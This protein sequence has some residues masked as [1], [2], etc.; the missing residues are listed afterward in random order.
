MVRLLSEGTL[1]AAE[2]PGNSEGLSRCWGFPVGAKSGDGL[3]LPPNSQPIYSLAARNPGTTTVEPNPARIPRPLRFGQI[4]EL[5]P[6]AYELRRSG[7][8]LKLERIPMEILLLLVEKKGHLVTRDEIVERVWGRETFLD[9]DNSINGAIR[10]LRQALKDDPEKPRVIQ[11]ITGKGYRFVA[12]VVEE[13]PPAS[14]ASPS[15]ASVP[16][17]E[18]EQSL[19]AK[20]ESLR[21]DP[22]SGRWPML[23][24]LAL[25]LIAAPILYLQRS[26][27]QPSRGRLM[28]AVLPFENLTGDSS[29]EYFSDG[30]TE[31]MISRLGAFDP[32]RLG[33]IARTSVMPYKHSR[34]RLDQIGRDLR[35]DYLLEGS[36]RREANRMRISAQLIQVRDGTHLW[37]R[38]Y[39]RELTSLL[40]VQEEIAQAVANEIDLTLTPGNRIGGRAE[41]LS[42]EA[43]EAYDLY[44]KGRYFWN[45]RTKE[46]FAQAVEHFG[47]AAERDPT[48]ARAYAGLADSYA[49]MS[50]YSPGSAKELMPKARSAALRALELDDRLAEAH[51]SLAL[52]RE[53]YD[54]D[55]EAAEREF[56]RAIQLN[57]SYATAHQWYAE[58][59]SFRGR[60]REAL[61][62]SD[63]A[64]RLDPLS[65]IIAADDAA[66]LYYARQYDR[67]IERFRAV[68]TRDP[69]FPRAYTIVWA[70]CQKQMFDEA[71]A[72]IEKW[73]QIDDG[74]WNWAAEVYVYGRQGRDAE[75]RRALERLEEFT[76]R[77]PRNPMV[78]L[79][80]AYVGVNEK[81]KALA[82][83]E[84]L[85]RERI[86]HPALKVDPLYDPLR[87][88]PRF[89]ELVR[90]AGL[91]E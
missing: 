67:S 25:L 5:D 47:R 51:T 68:I 54:W 44:L 63:R 23:L 53:R 26:R 16:S 50:T 62:E 75:A 39:D 29:Q 59:L 71:L 31:E 6:R 78:M 58:L 57:P 35:I 41:P 49:L 7:R 10:K 37:A 8:P 77:E 34:T 89:Q 13:A 74:P 30:L 82:S 87:E 12:T 76:R 11:T 48:Y 60:F 32:Q 3:S 36:V 45:K 27:A 81:E 46:D 69:A 91:A 38:Q 15:A 56:R 88:D 84:N 52:I 21:A 72:E 65:L 4:F 80:I 43:Y 18:P 85:F 19:A 73:R 61:E 1:A 14:A 20:T 79:P 55:W 22:L 9:T 83:L 17:V 90:R 70:Y 33:V 66:I 28:L 86:V 42:P 40:A 64:R 24:G 2:G